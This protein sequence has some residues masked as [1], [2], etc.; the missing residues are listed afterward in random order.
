MSFRDFSVTAPAF[1][2]SGMRVDIVDDASTFEQ[3]PLSEDSL[4]ISLGFLAEEDREETPDQLE[5]MEIYND[6][7][8]NS[9]DPHQL[10]HSLFPNLPMDTIYSALETNNYDFDAALNSLLSPPSAIDTSR[11]SNTSLNS[12]DAKSKTICRHFLAGGCYRANCWS[13]YLQ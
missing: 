11:S 9:L 13:D 5:I 8:L 7:S 4:N 12:S 1:K 3:A 10:L 6:E 2:P